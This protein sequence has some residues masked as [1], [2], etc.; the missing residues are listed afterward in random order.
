MFSKKK[1][2]PQISLPSNF[3]HRV[4][5]GFD[6][7]E[8]RY[9]GLP[10]Q[11]ASIVGNNQILKSTNRPLPLVD[12]SAITPT[13]I[14]DLKTIVRPQSS[15]ATSIGDN[16]M[17]S[18]ASSEFLNNP[19]NTSYNG[20]NLPK[21]SHVARSNSLR[22]SSPPRPHQR[23]PQIPNALPEEAPLQQYPL[24]HQVDPNVRKMQ[25]P[26]QNVQYLPMNS[27]LHNSNN[28]NNN[29]NNNALFNGKSNQI[30]SVYGNLQ[31][32]TSSH[33]HHTQGPLQLQQ[34]HFQ[35]KYSHDQ[36]Q[37]QQQQQQPHPPLLRHPDMINN[38]P[39]ESVT[40]SA[41]STGQS[42]G[43]P[44]LSSMSTL[45]GANKQEQRLTHEQFRAALQMVV[46]NGDPRENLEN[47]IK[48]GEGSTGTVWIAMEKNT[49]EL[50]DIKRFKNNTDKIS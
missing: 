48:I 30:Q 39:R 7:K 20:L 1:K 38:N 36:Q 6:K 25:Q 41:N 27:N 16:S 28:N 26:P 12:P 40:S 34:H 31:P 24:V 43:A 50:I 22:C 2:K 13:E 29:N 37:Q 9:I 19:Q 8:G 18:N 47:F 5:T 46:S 42:V 35:Q 17:S 15:L 14:L 10:L 32:P 45:N 3:E 4:H 49:S 44:N 21:I 11:W 23:E 33:Q